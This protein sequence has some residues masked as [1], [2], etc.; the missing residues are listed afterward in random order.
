MPKTIQNTVA[1]E[2]GCLQITALGGLCEIGKNT[3]AI[4]YGEDMMLV[5]AGL[6]FPSEDMPGVDIIL[7]DFTFLKEN[8]HKYWYCHSYRR[9]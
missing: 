1:A 5:D 4:V 6:G 7:P 9:L 2:P 3:M 8:A